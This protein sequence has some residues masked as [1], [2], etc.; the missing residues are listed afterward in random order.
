MDYV[1]LHLQ[2]MTP[3]DY[4]AYVKAKGRSPGDTAGPSM[5]QP[6]K[7]R[8]IAAVHSDSTLDKHV[9]QRKKAS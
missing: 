4:D 2:A 5:K 6:S 7:L 8:R 9:H 3:A 1:P